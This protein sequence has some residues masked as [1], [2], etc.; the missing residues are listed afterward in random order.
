MLRL[1]IID[2]LA[3]IPGSSFSALVDA[4]GL[5]FDLVEVC[6]YGWTCGGQIKIENIGWEILVGF[7]NQVG[8]YWQSHLLGWKNVTWYRQE[9]SCFRE[10]LASF[11][12]ISSAS[13]WLFRVWYSYQ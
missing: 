10:L 12:N 8:D 3:T 9:P 2:R 6:A 1:V 11:G 5:N 7:G 4:A 13:G